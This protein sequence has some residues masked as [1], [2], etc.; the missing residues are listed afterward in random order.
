MKG[1]VCFGSKKQ[2]FSEQARN[3]YREL[4]NEEKDITEYGRNWYRNISE[5]DKEKLKE[6]KKNY[7]YVKNND[8]IIIIVIIINIVCVV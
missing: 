1:N 3:K 6:Y 4:P 7:C 8:F 5:G 2:R